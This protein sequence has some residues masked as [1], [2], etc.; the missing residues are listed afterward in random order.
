MQ[1]W[2]VLQAILLRVGSLMTVPGMRQEA[3]TLAIK[4]AGAA[5]PLLKPGGEP[6]F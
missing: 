1:P 4:V 6:F 3:A 5:V 2:E